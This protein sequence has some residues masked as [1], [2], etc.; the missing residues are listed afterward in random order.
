MRGPVP[1]ES[2]V[3]LL[4]RH[5]LAVDGPTNRNGECAYRINGHTLTETEIRFLVGKQQVT[6]W[7]IY[8]FVRH[9]STK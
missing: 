1:I 4:R 3:Q 8:N 2:I 6:S 7:D 9:R 5:L